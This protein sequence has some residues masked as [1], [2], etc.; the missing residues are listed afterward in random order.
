MKAEFERAPRPQGDTALGVSRCTPSF[1]YQVGPPERRRP[2]GPG[3]GFTTISNCRLL[4]M[5]RDLELRRRIVARQVGERPVRNLVFRVL[6]ELAPGLRPDQALGAPHLLE[7]PV[8]EDL[9]DDDRLL[10][11]MVL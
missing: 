9:A 3:I 7:L 10:E 6:H 11:V 1:L 2:G 4:R 5:R 8:G